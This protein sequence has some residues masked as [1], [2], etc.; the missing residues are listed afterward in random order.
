MQSAEQGAYVGTVGVRRFFFLF[1]PVLLVSLATYLPLF[2]EKL[3]LGRISQ[4]AMAIAVNGAY[5]TQ[6]FQIPCVALA[7]MGQVY[8]G[9]WFGAGNYR[10]IGAGVWQLIWFSF[11]SMAV[12]LPLGWLYSGAHFQGVLLKSGGLP[13]CRFLIVMNFLY[14]LGA[15]LSCFYLGQGK[16][17]VI[18]VATVGAQLIKLVFAYLLIF[19]YS[20]WI[21]RLE[22]MGGT[23]STLIAQGSFCIFLL[24]NFLNSKNNALFHSRS[25]RF[26]PKLFWEC[27]YPGLLRATNRVLNSAAWARLAEIINAKGEDYC[28]SLSIGGT[29]FLFLPFIADSICQVQTTIVSQILG[30]KTYSLLSRALRSGVIFAGIIIV[31]AGIPLILLPSEIFTILFSKI[32]LD[33]M[34][35]KRIFFGVWISFAF[36]AFSFLPISHILAFKDMTFSLCMGVVCSAISFSFMYFLLEKT[37][38]SADKLWIALSISHLFTILFYWARMRWLQARLISSESEPSLQ[39]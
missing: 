15:A 20:T 19:G 35:I 38:L 36:F 17:K 5:V 23:I 25:W 28:L 7:M 39:T 37:Q 14:P 30:S 21:P 11:F 13:Y 27:L 29:L 3:F 31:L 8:I 4:E 22:L 34:S 10:S 24:W 18:L 1:L 32:T 12:V 2:M 26:Q 33:Q 6:I 9:R 16:T